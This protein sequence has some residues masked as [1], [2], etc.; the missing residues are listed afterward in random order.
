MVDHVVHLTRDGYQKLENELNYL[1]SVRRSEVAER[2]RLALEEGGDLVENA[3]YDDAKN[4]QA[5]IEGRIQQLEMMLS[6]ARI[7]EEV[8][9]EGPDDIVRLNSKVTVQE[10]GF[11]PE[12]FHIV[13][14]A[15]ADPRRGKISDVSP[16]GQALLGKKPGDKATVDAP[17]GQ[18]EYTIIAVEQ[19]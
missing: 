9:M 12:A 13:G 5:F 1:R 14:P 11:E 15:E 8:E 17:D 10:E 6:R 18:F 7:I 4:E 3:E 19:G 16:L 2:L